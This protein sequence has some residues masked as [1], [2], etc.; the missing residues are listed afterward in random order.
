[1]GVLA[2]PTCHP[3]RVIFVVLPSNS[4][5]FLKIVVSHF[6]VMEDGNS[7]TKVKL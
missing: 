4:I 1:M 2:S 6:F 7:V 5:P 3:L